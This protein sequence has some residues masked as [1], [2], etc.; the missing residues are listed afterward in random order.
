MNPYHTPSRVDLSLDHSCD[1]YPHSHSAHQL[2]TVGHKYGSD[3]KDRRVRRDT[4]VSF[5]APVLHS[6]SG[7][8]NDT[9]DFVPPQVRESG[10]AFYNYN[11][12]PV[13]AFYD[14]ALTIGPALKPSSFS[15]APRRPV[16]VPQVRRHTPDLTI[17]SGY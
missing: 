7:W 17:S 14:I 3:L 5:F 1:S 10:L 13:F 12:P 15:L 16:F 6:P 11:N 2:F 8:L 9:T 4:F